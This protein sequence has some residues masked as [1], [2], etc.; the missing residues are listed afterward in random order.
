VLEGVFR[1]TIANT[2]GRLTV[3]FASLLFWVVYYSFA[4]RGKRT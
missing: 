2:D 4:G 3:A 1:Q